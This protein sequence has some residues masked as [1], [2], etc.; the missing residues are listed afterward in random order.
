MPVRHTFTDTYQDAAG[1]GQV[2]HLRIAHLTPSPPS[3]SP[4][5]EL[6]PGGCE[7]FVGLFGATK[8]RI[9]RR[10]SDG[11]R[12]C[13]FRDGNC[14]VPELNST[15]VRL[16]L[17]QLSKTITRVITVTQVKFDFPL[18]H[19]TSTSKLFSQGSRLLITE[20]AFLRTI[21]RMGPCY[22]LISDALVHYQI[23]ACDSR[24]LRH[25]RIY[26]AITERT[27]QSHQLVMETRTQSSLSPALSPAPTPRNSETLSL[28]IDFPDMSH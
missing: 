12:H 14:V 13:R 3:R 18:L 21:V 27:L 23:W 16:Q 24:A 2:G 26:G 8:P 11:A 22:S 19:S 5:N 10:A 15:A 1:T 6:S 17:Q 9:I 25:C 20:Q 28:R 4:S 7:F